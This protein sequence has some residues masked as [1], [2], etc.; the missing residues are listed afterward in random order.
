MENP[1]DSEICFDI[2]KVEAENKCKPGITTVAEVLEGDTNAVVNISGR[3]TF[4]SE[5]ETVFAKGKTLRKREA[6]FTDNSG[7]IRLVLW[8]NDIDRVTSASICKVVVREYENVKYL[9]LNK[10]S[11]IKSANISVTRKDG[12]AGLPNTEKV[13]CLAE[14]VL[15]VQRFSSC[16]K[17]R[18]KLIP[19]GAKPLECGSAQLINKCQQRLIANVMFLKDGNNISLLS[20]EDKLKQVYDIYKN[21]FPEGATGSFESLDDDSLM[22]MPLTVEATVCFNKKK[23]QLSVHKKK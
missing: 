22:E 4:T 12:A 15:S 23:N 13:N 21:Q 1:L 20:F 5:E 17:C 19:N 7:T 10:S 9:T 11:T 16:R 18:T 6:L 14:G 3:I 2:R 8:E